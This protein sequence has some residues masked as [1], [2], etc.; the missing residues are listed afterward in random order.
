MNYIVLEG[1]LGKTN[2]IRQTNNG[3]TTYSFTV[4]DNVGKDKDPNW[5]RVVLW[6]DYAEKKKKEIDDKLA[7]KKSDETIKIVARGRIMIDHYK[8]ENGEQTT[9]YDLNADYVSI[10]L[11]K[12]A[13]YAPDGNQKDDDWR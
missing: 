13:D 5:F 6:G 10:T 2:D 8:K 12:K 3:K 7:A 9:R 4:A 1:H 11:A